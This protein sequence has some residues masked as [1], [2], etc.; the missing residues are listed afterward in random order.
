MAPV[1]WVCGDPKRPHSAKFPPQHTLY[2]VPP[3]TRRMPDG[4]ASPAM[5]A[6]FPSLP[7]R[8]PS[9]AL[10]STEQPAT[11][12]LSSS[13]PRLGSM[14][15]QKLDVSRLSAQRDSYAQLGGGRPKS[16]LLRKQQDLNWFESAVLSRPGAAAR[17][18]L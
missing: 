7:P 13:A 14:R 3:P 18:G 11:L 8:V 4:R 9:P 5:G 12:R 1:I 10:Q 15:P 6:A 16:A 17:G 2:R